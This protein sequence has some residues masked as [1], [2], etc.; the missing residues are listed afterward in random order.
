MV[1]RK[2]VHQIVSEAY[3][4]LEKLQPTTEEID[5]Y[6]DFVEKKYYGVVTYSMY[7]GGD[8]YFLKFHDTW[9]VKFGGR[10]HID[11]GYVDEA[12]M[13]KR[14]VCNVT[15]LMLDK[16][17]SWEFI[18]FIKKKRERATIEG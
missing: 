2:T 14:N 1:K 18:E 7:R 10:I 8:T 5:E 16:D 12:A 3:D 17:H 13:Y 11:L 15:H 6:A 4:E 9:Q